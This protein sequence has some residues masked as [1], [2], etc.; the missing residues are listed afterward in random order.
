MAEPRLLAAGDQALV[1]EFSDRIDPQDNARVI[2][3]DRDLAAHPIPGVMETTPSYR[4][5]L[6]Q[7]DPD[8][9]RGAALGSLLLER[10]AA[11]RGETLAR[12]LWHVP[13]LYGG[14]AGLDLEEIARLK[15]LSP[16]EVI[17]LHAG[18]E[19]RV[20]MIGFVPGYA[21]LGGLPEALHLPR[22]ATPRQL[23]PAGGIAIGGRQ[24]SVGSVASPS[25]W[26]FLG[27][28]PLRSF[29]PARSRPFVFEAG[30]AIRFHAIAEAEAGRLDALSARGEICADLEEM[31][32]H[33]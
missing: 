1:V 3:L 18:A 7:Y 29:D 21:Y 5:L 16:A 25:G 9:I 2:A 20:Y 10:A 30:D 22:L 26:R 33:S 31:P 13:V 17:G 19:Y 8:V 15:G 6:V 27:R 14:A 24:A 23:T 28:T 12:R 11:A 4:S 32:R